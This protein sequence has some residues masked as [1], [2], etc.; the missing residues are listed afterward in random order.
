M[1]QP[2]FRRTQ[3]RLIFIHCLYLAQ[4]NSVFRIGAI[5]QMVERRND[6][7]EIAEQS[8]FEPALCHYFSSN[9]VRL[10]AYVFTGVDSQ[11]EWLKR[12]E[13]N[14]ILVSDRIIIF[15]VF[16]SCLSRKGPALSNQSTHFYPMIFSI[17]QHYSLHILRK[18]DWNCDYMK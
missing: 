6:D 10:F 7:L 16:V 15:S 14:R 4:L 9:N 1:T 13:S 8:W 17:I 5:A 3:S 2:R 12:N 18:G 11:L